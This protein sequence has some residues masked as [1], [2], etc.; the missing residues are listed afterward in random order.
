MDI[1]EYFYQNPP[2]NPKFI[3]R[4]TYFNG[5]KI[6]LQGAIN[7]GKTA[8]LIQY[9]EEFGQ[10]FLY[11]NLEDIRVDFIPNLNEFIKDKKIKAIGFDGV[12]NDFYTPCKCDNI[13]ISTTSNS[14]FIDKF[15]KVKLNGLDYEEFIAFYRKNYE[16]KTLFSHFLA[17]G[18]GAKSAFLQ[19]FEVSE[20]LQM[21]IKAYLG[22]QKAK[23]L[24]KIAAYVHQ[25]FNTHKIYK[26]LKETTKI[27]KDNI[28]RILSEFE[29]E[30]LINFVH[31][32]DEKSS[33][34]RV[35]FSDFG[36]KNA[37]GYEKD[38]KKT[39][40]NMVFCE[41]L[42]LENELFFSDEID[43][44]IPKKNLAILVIPF[45]PPEFIFLKF[46][47]SINYYKNLGIT[48][49]EVISN[50]NNSNIAFEGIRCSVMPFWQ[51]AVA[52]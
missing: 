5:N 46:K 35:Y 15:T 52:L 24:S 8:L 30:N 10:D 17:R 33:L 20:F 4:K 49:V 19:D 3:D 51:W 36:F 47:K 1:L 43:F 32:I 42:K 23:I 13:I 39:V 7:S 29:N 6:I 44:F 18:N 50:S 9:L 45:L 48:K 34:K 38:P 31:H 27:S 16:A 40:A 37:L 22:E 41:L 25:P 14:F 26:D 21:K 12:K 11:L 2:K 28:Y